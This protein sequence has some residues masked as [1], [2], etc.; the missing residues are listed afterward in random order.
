MN[1]RGQGVG[2]GGAHL[3]E[4]QRSCFVAYTNIILHEHLSMGTSKK[5]KGDREREKEE[6]TSSKKRR[7]DSGEEERESSSK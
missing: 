6:R 2:S 1:G 4:F 5:D 7:R 3:K